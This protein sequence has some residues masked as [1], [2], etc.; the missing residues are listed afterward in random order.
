MVRTISA[1]FVA[2]L[3]LL[4]GAASAEDDPSKFYMFYIAGQPR[5]VVEA[6]WQFCSDQASVVL[7]F[8][9]KIGRPGGLITG[10]VTDMMSSKDRFRMRSAA[11][12]RCMGMLGYD[13]YAM[14]EAD[15]RALVGEG[16]LVM[17]KDG[18]IDHA[19]IAKFAEVAAGP[20]PSSGKLDR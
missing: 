6:D 19:R 8:S 13:R 11:M 15:W 20:M 10:I 9:D 2:G 14:S 4:P 1:F 18:I 17:R 3:L 12:R 16:D 7:S 5:A